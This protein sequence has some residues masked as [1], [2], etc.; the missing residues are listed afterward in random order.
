MLVVVAKSVRYK[1]EVLDSGT[2]EIE[3]RIEREIHDDASAWI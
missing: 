2:I 1:S 3:S